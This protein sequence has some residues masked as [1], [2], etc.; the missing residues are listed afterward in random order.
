MQYQITNISRKIKIPV[1]F[2][3]LIGYGCHYIIQKLS[4]LIK[5]EEEEESISIK[6][7]PYN[8]EKYVLLL[9]TNLNLLIVYNS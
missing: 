2:H 6:V 3:N 4:E 9:I 5:E 7:I 8:A 1:I